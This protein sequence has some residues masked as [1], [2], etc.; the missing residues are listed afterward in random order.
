MEE[1]GL[2]SSEDDED[3]DVQVSRML[4]QRK[5]ADLNNEEYSQLELESYMMGEETHQA[6][7]DRLKSEWTGWAHDEVYADDEDEEEDDNVGDMLVVPPQQQVQ[8][9]ANEKISPRSKSRSMNISSMIQ[10][11]LVDDCSDEEVKRRRR[12]RRKNKVCS[13]YASTAPARTLTNAM[14]SRIAKKRYTKTRY[15]DRRK[16]ACH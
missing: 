14:F 10:Q 11:E 7:V 6:L 3:E 16:S 13:P 5:D 9:T 8:P 15:P 12:E 1:E 2:S 4:R